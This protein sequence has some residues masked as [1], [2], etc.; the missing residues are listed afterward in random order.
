VTPAGALA[1]HELQQAARGRWLAA[2]AVGFA[3]LALGLS[4]VGL[5]VEGAAGLEGYGR[6]TASL[7]NLSLTLIPL[8]ALLLGAGG[9]AGDRETGALEVLLAQPLTRTGL[10]LGRFAG[11]LAAVGL[12]TVLGFGVAGTLIGLAAGSSGGAQYL[13]Y[14]AIALLLAAAYLAIGTVVAVCSRTRL[15]ATAAALAIWFASVVLFDL[16]LIGLGAAAG[17]SARTLAVAML[18]NPVEIARVLA[19][20]VLDPGLEMLGPVGGLLAA[21]LGGAGAAAALL[22]ALLAWIAGPLAL[23]AAIFESRDPL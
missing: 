23:A 6:T 1:R 3:V 16:A 19:L 17:A 22:V 11:Q 2:F 8:V 12:A 21:R 10:L 7:L 14:V 13:A 20:L 4:L 18:F 9:V 15:A 5:R